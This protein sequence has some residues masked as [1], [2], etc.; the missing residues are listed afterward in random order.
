MVA[1]QRQ[2]AARNDTARQL[3]GGDDASRQ[4]VG[5]APQRHLGILSGQAIIA[6][7]RHPHGDGYP[8]AP[9]NHTNRVAQEDGLQEGVLFILLCFGHIDELHGQGDGRKVTALVELILRGLPH[10]CIALRFALLLAAFS[11][12]DLLGP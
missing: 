1:A 12:G 9:G 7:F 6:V 8:D 10:L 11:L 2:L 5:Y 3:P 4:S